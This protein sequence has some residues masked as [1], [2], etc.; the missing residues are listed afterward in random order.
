MPVPILYVSCV[1]LKPDTLLSFFRWYEHRHA[2]DLLNTGFISINSYVCRVGRPLICN[3]YEIPTT[4]LFRTPAY[5]NLGMPEFDPELPRIMRG[6][7][8]RSNVPYRQVRTRFTPAGTASESSR[9]T[10]HLDAP[11]VTIVRFNCDPSRDG[12]VHEWAELEFRRTAEISGCLGG[13]LCE[14][15]RE[16]HPSNPSPEVPRWLFVGE[17]TS[18]DAAEA[19]G[20]SDLIQCNLLEIGSNVANFDYCQAIRVLTARKEMC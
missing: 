4:S 2:A 1:D 20:A 17:W 9:R 15:D 18:V 8:G 6:L 12:D 10:D 13:R 11:V 16:Q 7:F 3:L 5:A 19:A 14:R